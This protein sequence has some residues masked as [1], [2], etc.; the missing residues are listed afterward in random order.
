MVLMRRSIGAAVPLTLVVMLGVASSALAKEG[1]ALLD[2]AP[3]DDPPG[4]TVDVGFVV[5]MPGPD[6]Q[7]RLAGAN[8]FV[9][10]RSGS[11]PG[12]LAWASEQP[13]ASGHYVVSFVVPDGG[14]QRLDFGLA[15]PDCRTR[16][17]ANNG[18]MLQLSD[19]RSG[20]AAPAP[21]AQ[22][23]P[24]SQPQQSRPAPAQSPIPV[25]LVVLVAGAI[26]VA[27]G[28]LV[29][30]RGPLSPRRGARPT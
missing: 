22:P 18:F 5:Q 17:C 19:Q 27:G 15:D 12:L 26:A 1:M 7:D 2:A 6:S 8:A 13:A 14:I 11:G 28:A 21:A 23:Q 9:R 3:P 16:S 30:G 20:V 24:Q 10:V 25:V 29:M 4:T